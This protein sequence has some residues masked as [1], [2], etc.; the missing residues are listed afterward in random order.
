MEGLCELPVSPPGF[1]GCEGAAAPTP[2]CSWAVGDAAEFVFVGFA[3]VLTFCLA[4]SSG[5]KVW[6]HKG[7]PWAFRLG[8]LGF[9][10]HWYRLLAASTIIAVLCN[11]GQDFMEEMA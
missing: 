7:V 1:W 4:F 11:R 5:G 9:A 6:D 3:N 2:H 8:S 10:A